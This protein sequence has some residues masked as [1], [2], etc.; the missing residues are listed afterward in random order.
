MFNTHSIN[1]YFSGGSVSWNIREVDYNAIN[2]TV[3]VRISQRHSWRRSA[4]MG[5][6]KVP[7]CDI[8]TIHNGSAVIGEGFLNCISDECPRLGSSYLTIPTRVSC[9]DFSVEY[10]YASG[11]A[12]R[13]IQLPV[14]YQFTYSF[15]SCCWISLLPTSHSPSW[16]LNVTI[17]T[18]R[19]AN[20]R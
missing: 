6:W 20:G 1:F 3:G 17:T 11:E 12:S 8:D 15:S 2:T 7:E 16:K 4:A 10:D 18:N 9:T 14:G 13:M 19:R 5:F